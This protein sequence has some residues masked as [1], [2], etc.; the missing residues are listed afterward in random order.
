MPEQACYSR[1]NEHA[2]SLYQPCA[3]QPGNPGAKSSRC[4]LHNCT[5][6]ASSASRCKKLC[7]IHFRSNNTP[8]RVPVGC[9]PPHQ[10]SSRS[11]T[12][13]ASRAAAASAASAAASSPSHPA[14]RA[15]PAPPRAAAAQPWNVRASSRCLHHCTLPS[16]CTVM[17]LP[18][19]EGTIRATNFMSARQ[20]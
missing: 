12:S 19:M 16:L 9:R 14:S 13:A 3:Q 11:A 5:A 15:R 1:S 17:A 20:E 18:G 10:R 8:L 4:A 7:H 2:D 6:A